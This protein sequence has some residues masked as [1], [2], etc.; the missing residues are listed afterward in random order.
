MR[1]LLFLAMLS[2]GS[3]TYA[4]EYGKICV[5]P[6]AETDS[7]QVSVNETKKYGLSEL[8][9]VCINEVSM[10]GKNTVTIFRRNI[11]IQ[12][13]FVEFVPSKN[14]LACISYNKTNKKWVNNWGGIDE[15]HCEF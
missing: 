4:A 8:V 14:E 12:E 13:L 1:K 2:I 10:S 7:F 15:E 3:A 6:T 5:G 11:K 9:H